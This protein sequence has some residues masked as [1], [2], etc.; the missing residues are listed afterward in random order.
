[1]SLNKPADSQQLFVGNHPHNCK[2][3]DLYALF[4]K[5]GQ[6]LEVRINQ[7]Q[8]GREANTRTGR[9]GRPTIVPNFGF[10]V[11]AEPESVDR[12]LSLKHKPILLIQGTSHRL[13][14]EGKKNPSRLRETVS[15]ITD[16]E[17]QE[18]RRKS[19][20]ILNKLTPQNLDTVVEKFEGLPIDSFEKLSL[21]MELIFQKALDEPN[22]SATYAQMCLALGNK[23][24][25]DETGQG[26]TSFRKLLIMRCQQEFEKDYMEGLDREKYVN[27]I[28]KATNEDDKK[29]IK[30]EFEAN[31]MKLKKRSLG[32]IRFIGELYKLSMLTARIMHECV[33]KLLTSNPSDEEALECLCRLLTTVGQALDKETND[34]LAKGPIQGLVDLGS[35][36]KEMMKLVEQ[37]KTSARVRFLMQDVIELRLNGWKK[38]REDAGPKTIDQIHKEIEKEQ[39]EQKLA[40]MAPMGP[41]PNRR[42][43][44]RNDRNDDRRRSQKG[45][46]GGG[47]GHGGEDGWQAVPTRVASRSQ[48]EKIDTNK[49]RNIGATKLDADSMSFGPPKGGAGGAGG[50]GTWG[51][52]SQSAK[53]SRQEPTNMQNRFA[54]L[55]QSESGPPQ[56]Y[57][58]RSSGGRFGRQNSQ[59]DRGYGGR[60]SRGASGENDRAKAI[61]AVRDFGGNRSQSVMGPHP[62]VSRENS[63]P[64]SASMVVQ[65]KAEVPEVPLNGPANASYNDLE[66]WTEPLLKEFCHNVDYNE[67]IK[68]IGEKFSPET[69]AQFVEIV[70]NQVL[71]QSDKARSLTGNLLSQ[72]VKKHMVT[73]RQY[74]EGL[75][76]LLSMAEDLL[77]DIPKLWDFMA[78][79]VAPVLSS[80]CLGLKILKDSATAANLHSGELG[81]RCAAGK[82]AAAVL[83]EMGKSG[84]IAVAKMWRES[85]LQWSDFLTP[86]TNVEEFLLSNKL[87]WTVE[88]QG[89]D[90]GDVGGEL[91]D[92]SIG[93]EIRKVLEANRKSN[94]T[95]FDWVEKHCSSKLSSPSFIRVLTTVVIE[96]VIDGLGGPTNDCKLNEEQLKLRN[97]VLKKFLDGNPKLEMQALLAM[98]Y[99]MHKLEHPNKLL[100]SIFEKVYD[101]DVVSEEAF[102]AW[103]KNDDPH[104]QEGK[105]VA[106]KSCTQFFT[107]LQ[108]A[109]EED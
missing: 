66:K 40:H 104:E 88:G 24:V 86:D 16:T 26:V 46:P 83:H 64:R 6:V 103:S 97:P 14:V 80:G 106:L 87:E 53:T 49:L 21:C 68:E 57:D 92:D 36:F 105:G 17:V 84:H 29:R 73:E 55:E 100:H 65:K 42:D 30:M 58:G 61:Q 5:F 39:L 82:Y 94:D 32:N 77:V 44:R 79:I 98:Q 70:L 18:L 13:H 2:E 34:R 54:Q 41:P 38:R 1:M 60:N 48:Y 108:E 25:P 81:E 10:V 96:S 93:R 43:D 90:G 12:A 109:E 19:L 56:S 102:M 69:I 27:D 20:A 62:T 11:F 89:G 101:D 63:A 7:K 99:L 59:Q 52:G 47:G 45:G 75:N 3:D 50:F 23:K 85:G 35:Y 33:R 71:E 76:V 95:L 51:R 15:S 91:S 22:F 78:Q 107:W 72:L 4:S 28:N 74:M 31:E 37:K 9:D 8:G 67:A